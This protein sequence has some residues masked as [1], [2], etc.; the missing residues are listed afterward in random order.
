MIKTQ[1][2]DENFRQLAERLFDED[3]QSYSHP[4]SRLF[5]IG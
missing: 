1:S 5:H 2:K 4:N 3:M